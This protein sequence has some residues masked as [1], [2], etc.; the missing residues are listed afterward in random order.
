MGSDMGWTYTHKRKGQTITD[1]F[2]EQ[3]ENDHFKILTCKTYFR[4]EVYLLCEAIPKDGSPVYNFAA[5]CLIHFC[6]R[7]PDY[8]FGYKDMDQSC[9]PNYYNCPDEILD[10]ISPTDSEYA[11]NWIAACRANN[12]E[13]RKHHAKQ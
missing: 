12:A 10:E 2:R 9:G 13:K 5:M 1:F 6:P 11:N 8:N 4:R 3:W 7:D